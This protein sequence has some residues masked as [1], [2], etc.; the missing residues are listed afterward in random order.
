M[1]AIFWR[2]RSFETGND[3][4]LADRAL[5]GIR[6]GLLVVRNADGEGEAKARG[7]LGRNFPQEFPVSGERVEFEDFERVIVAAV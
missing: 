5:I 3:E 2:S 6:V 4:E 7:T 1:R